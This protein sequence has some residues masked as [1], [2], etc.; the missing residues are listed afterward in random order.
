MRNSL[1]LAL[2]IL[3]LM[4]AIALL[5]HFLDWMNLTSDSSS[6]AACLARFCRWSQGLQ[7]SPPSGEFSVP[8]KTDQR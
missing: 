6:G 3:V 7:F 5:S 2:T 8:D 1:Q 4:L